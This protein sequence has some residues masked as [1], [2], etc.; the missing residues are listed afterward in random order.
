[1]CVIV[2]YEVGSI[3]RVTRFQV[4]ITLHSASF[5]P[6]HRNLVLHDSIK[7]VSDEYSNLYSRRRRLA[8]Q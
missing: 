1:M 7:H 3:H 8:K 4:N 6:E 2:A 5:L